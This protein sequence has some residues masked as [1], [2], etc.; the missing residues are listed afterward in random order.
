MVSR[1]I[2]ASVVIVIVLIALVSLGFYY[3]D[4]YHKL[5]FQLST[6]NVV[7]LGVSSLVMNFGIEIH[8]PNAL[9]IYVPN[10]DF[11]VYINNVNLGR[12]TFGSTTIGGNSQDQIVVPLTISASDVSSVLYGIVLGGGNITVTIQG[13]ANL[14]LFSVPFTSTAYNVAV[15]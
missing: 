13:S 6:V 9:P 2:I 8:N 1:K 7:D 14:I 11:Q 4:A 12:G 15:K 3:Y 5:T 10:G